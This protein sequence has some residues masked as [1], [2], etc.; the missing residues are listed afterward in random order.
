MAPEQAVPG[1]RAHGG[2]R[3]VHW[4]PPPFVSRPAG[5][6]PASAVLLVSLE[7][8]HGRNDEDQPACE[9]QYL[10]ENESG[11]NASDSDCEDD[12][13]A[14]SHFCADAST[15]R[16]LFDASGATDLLL[17]RVAIHDGS[18]LGNLDC[19]CASP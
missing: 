9:H 7:P 16:S 13:V 4:S 3:S 17:V 12:P 8:M 6:L 15:W 5:A 19:H 10:T 14:A 18:F 2:F 1:F 11:G